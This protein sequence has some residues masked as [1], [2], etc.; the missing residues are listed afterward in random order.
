LY[1]DP[2]VKIRVGN[3]VPAAAEYP[4]IGQ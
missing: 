1:R 4:G 2:R 3:K